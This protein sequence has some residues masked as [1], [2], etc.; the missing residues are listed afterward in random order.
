MQR[1]TSASGWAMRL[2]R[3]SF[4]E[5]PVA[6]AHRPE[7]GSASMVA[8]SPFSVPIRRQSSTN[9]TRILRQPSLL[10]PRESAARMM[11]SSPLQSSRPIRDKHRLPAINALVDPRHAHL[12]L[13]R[14]RLPQRPVPHSPSPFADVCTMGVALLAVTSGSKGR[15]LPPRPAGGLSVDVRAPPDQV[16]VPTR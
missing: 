9:W 15:L 6:I 4:G 8:Q 14:G 7:L 16:S 10:P 3:L 2:E 11:L 1:S 5:G 12:R 13:A